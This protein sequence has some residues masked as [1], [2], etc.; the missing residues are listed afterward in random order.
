MWIDLPEIN[1]EKIAIKLKPSAE[2]MVKKSHPW[3]FDE[4]IKKQSIAGKAGDLV[5]V[6]DTKKNK[7]L[8]C[9][10]FDP[11]SPI[12][13]KILQ[14]HKSANINADWFEAKIAAAYALRQ[15]LLQTKTNSYRLLYGESDCLPS[16]VTDVYDQVAV[17]KI[18]SGIWFPYL[19]D[20]L[21]VIQKTINC[22]T[23]VLRLSR[24]LMDK[25]NPVGLQDGQVLFGELKNEDVVFLEHGVR[26]SANVIHGHKTGHF[27]DHRNNRKKVGE[28][29]KG[30]S[31]LDVF[32]YS[33]G[34]S[35]H[36][37]CGGAET[38]TSIDI[39]Q[40]ALEMAEKNAALN[41]FSGRHV[42]LTM[43]A[44]DGMQRLVTYDKTF[45]LVIIDPPSFAKR[46]SEVERALAAYRRLAKMAIKLTAKNGT[47]ILAS[48]SSRVSA[49]EFFEL[50]LKELE[51]SGRNFHL[52]EKTFHDIDHP[53]KPNFPE[54]AYLKCGYYSLK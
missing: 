35:V 34:F 9:G 18:Y 44:F 46:A 1:T 52:M 38:V 23:L 37:L 29:A 17:V 50:N 10:L 54:A 7:F 28:M 41:K 2:R 16:L 12:R 27:L 19:K 20:I 4:G 25:K 36:A 5:I 21:P 13:I 15:P 8:A 45:D 51:D 26:F 39:S 24:S 31:V 6:F 40:Q 32:S 3:V 42:C 53:V 30:K 33:G 47:L 48:C 11:Q 14:A 43:D 22:E 49:D